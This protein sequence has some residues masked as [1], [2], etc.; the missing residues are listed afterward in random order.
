M[1]IHYGLRLPR[2]IETVPIVRDLCRTALTQLGVEEACVHD[3]ALAL[4]EACANVVEH[5]E[6]TDDDYEVRLQ[7]DNERC[8]IRVVDTGRGFDADDLHDSEMPDTHAER[9]RGIQLMKALVDQ[10]T[11]VSV[12]EKGTIVHFQKDL[13]LVEGSPLHSLR[14]RPKS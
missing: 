13:A 2:E 8:D 1:E 11:F 3:V 12:P 10:V 4:T 9:G 7:V 6:G 5:A 14:I